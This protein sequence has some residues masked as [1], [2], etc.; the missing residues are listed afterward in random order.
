VWFYKLHFF[1]KYK[2]MRF[3]AKKGSGG[4]F[5]R[6]RR[7][8]KRKIKNNEWSEVAW[9][10]WGVKRTALAN[11]TLPPHLRQAVYGHLKRVLLLS[12]C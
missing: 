8:E 12:V 9:R 5:L 3:A 6:L 11:L 7:K 1:F 10:K 2:K 4:G